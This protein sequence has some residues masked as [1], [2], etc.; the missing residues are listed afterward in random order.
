[1]ALAFVKAAKKNTLVTS[2]SVLQQTIQLVN[3][4]RISGKKNE[5]SKRN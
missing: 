2:L 1:M 3:A 5:K 4:R